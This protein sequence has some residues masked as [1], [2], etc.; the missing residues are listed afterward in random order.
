MAIV[1]AEGQRR[2]STKKSLAELIAS[3][4]FRADRHWKLVL[5][6]SQPAGV[7]D[8]AWAE[9]VRLSKAH[10]QKQ[11]GAERRE[12]EK[13]L[14]KSDLTDAE[15]ARYAGMIEELTCEVPDAI[16]EVIRWL[17]ERPDYEKRV[18]LATGQLNPLDWF[19]AMSEHPLPSGIKTEP[20]DWVIS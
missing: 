3:G 14:A 5:E 17:I 7:P 15:Q 1:S 2:V 10:L 13:L 16:P 6:G 4:G 11:M 12:A 8:H 19:A 9:I 18:A 20:Q